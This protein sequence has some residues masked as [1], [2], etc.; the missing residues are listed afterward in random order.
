MPFGGGPHLCVGKQFA[1]LEAQV[2]LAILSRRFDMRHLPTHPVV[3]HATITLRPKFGMQMTVHPR[4][5]V[6]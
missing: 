3:N 1:L 2:L 6:K 4:Q 5:V